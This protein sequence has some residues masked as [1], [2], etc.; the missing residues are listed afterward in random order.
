MKLIDY[1]PLGKENKKSMEEIMAD[2]NI[3]RKQDFRRLLQ[4]TRKENVIIFDETGYF[5]PTKKQEVYD[6]IEK[7]QSKIGEILEVLNQCYQEAKKL[8]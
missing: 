5:R 6:F 8:K 4:E 7:Y 3:P 1:I 2:A